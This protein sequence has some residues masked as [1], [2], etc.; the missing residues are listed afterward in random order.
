MKRWLALS[1]PRLA[2][3]CDAAACISNDATAI[4]EEAR[5]R[6][7][8]LAC[9]DAALAA[10]LHT[11]Q[12]L[13]EAYALVPALM[14][15]E[16][17]AAVTTGHLEKLALWAMQYSSEVAIEAPGALLLEVAASERLFGNAEA[18]L[19]RIHHHT[20]RRGL[21]LHA[22]VAPT[23]SAALLLAGATGQ[24]PATATPIILDSHAALV[25]TLDALPVSALPLDDFTL[26]GLRQSGIRQLSELRALPMS[27]LTRRFGQSLADMLYRLDGR[28]P[29]PRNCI[30][31]PEHFEETLDLP[32]ETHDTGALEFVLKRLFDALEGFL[33]QRDAGVGKLVLRL[34]HQR[35]PATRL[36][37]RFLDAHAD[38]HHLLR[39][40][41]ARLGEKRLDEPVTALGL[42]AREFASVS[43]SRRD[44]FQHAEGDRS[45]LE[46][47]LDR[48]AARLGPDALFMATAHDDHRPE[49]ACQKTL[50][51]PPG[52]VGNWPTRP[53]WLLAE[54]QPL[55]EA[56][57]L[58]TPP[59]RIENGWWSSDDV[60]RDYFI[61][62][63]ADG[64]Y[65]WVFRQRRAPGNLW[66][67]GVF[68]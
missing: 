55:T 42:E 18:L 67:H 15:R 63:H 36:T 35:G 34:F 32:V 3:E 1:F 46:T 37:L 14:V 25:T 51:L 13:N 45:D 5:G 31:P 38:S 66:L 61:A 49:M 58:E 60:R 50:L 8:L 48:L 65:F 23:P 56:V 30:T 12:S 41:R 26:K 10:G 20:R 2:I 24:A 27:A 40:A 6:R 57:T 16:H 53:V 19:A 39:V 52:K 43:Q 29:D 7:V 4:I 22:A 68:A 33:R 47:V 21:T 62:R 11:G 54:P 64:R 28:L 44:L 59:E 9:N 17:D